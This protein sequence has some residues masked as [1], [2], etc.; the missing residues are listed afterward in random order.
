MKLESLKCY[1]VKTG[2]LNSIKGGFMV[3]SYNVTGS[4]SYHTHENS[5]GFGGASWTDRDTCKDFTGKATGE[6]ISINIDL[7]W[8]KALER[9]L[10][11]E[12]IT[13]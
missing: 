5:G 11:G 8:L 1:Q 4:Y 3:G 10:E 12:D 6:G 13:S 2:Q 7:H 9:E